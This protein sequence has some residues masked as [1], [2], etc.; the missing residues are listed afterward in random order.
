MIELQGSF[1]PHLKKKYHVHIKRQ[2]RFLFWKY[3]VWVTI[4]KF[5]RKS[6]ADYFM[7]NY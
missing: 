5:S 7:E 6:D 1:F 3:D 4:A 2:K